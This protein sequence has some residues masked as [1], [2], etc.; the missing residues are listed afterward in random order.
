MVLSNKPEDADISR[1][2]TQ[3]DARPLP[4]AGIE[5]N[6]CAAKAPSGA[7]EKFRAKRL[8]YATWLRGRGADAQTRWL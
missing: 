8:A 1:I 6:K 7:P 3:S 5:K 2:S 4:N